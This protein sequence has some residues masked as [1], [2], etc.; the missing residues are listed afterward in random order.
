MNKSPFSN[1]LRVLLEKIE[2]QEK[3]IS[4]QEQ[5]LL[6]LKMKVKRLHG[7]KFHIV[8]VC[9]RP[10]NWLSFQS[11]YEAF[12]KDEDFT[13]TIVAIPYKISHGKETNTL[14]E[15][16]DEGAYEFFSSF[17]CQV[18]NGYNK[19]THEWNLSLTSACPITSHGARSY[20][21]SR[22]HLTT[23]KH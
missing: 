8:F 4:S 12:M 1:T 20:D 10:Q 3:R 11:I 2:M 17:T 6:W 15:Y 5:T 9:H 22:Q 23:L 21:S 16:Y 13:V 18:V 19:Y 14:D 7:E